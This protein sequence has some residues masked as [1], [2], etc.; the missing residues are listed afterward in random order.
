MKL[1]CFRCKKRFKERKDIFRTS[2]NHPICEECFWVY[3]L[4]DWED[5]FIERIIQEVRDKFNG[6]YN[7]WKENFF[8][9]MVKCDGCKDKYY[10]EMYYVKE[11][12]IEINGKKYCECCVEEKYD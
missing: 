6:K 5:E 1:K 3:L 12:I 2:S 10:D 11:T 8:K 9:T 7:R 4:N